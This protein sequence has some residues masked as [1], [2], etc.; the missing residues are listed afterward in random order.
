MRV[1]HGAPKQKHQ[2]TKPNSL[3]AALLRDAPQGADNAGA[4]A[5]DLVEALG[6]ATAP[7]KAPFVLL[8]NTS[9]ELQGAVRTYESRMEREQ[10]GWRPWVL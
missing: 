6:G 5:T 4:R 8:I 2:Q 3:R 7:G 1:S 9:R 10:Q